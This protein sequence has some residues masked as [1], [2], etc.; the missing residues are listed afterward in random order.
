MN[1]GELHSRIARALGKGTSLDS[2]IPSFVEEGVQWLEA[3]YNF[4]YMKRWVEWTI[5]PNVQQPHVISLYQTKIKK[6]EAVRLVV[7]DP[8]HLDAN[9]AR[10]KD[11]RRIDPKDRQTRFKGPPS[12]YWLDGMQ[13]IVLDSIPTEAGI[14]EGHYIAFTSWQPNEPEFR[15]YLIDRYLTPLIART[16]MIAAIDRRDPRMYDMYKAAYLDAQTV[17]NVSEEDLQYGSGDQQMSW[18]PE[19]IFN[20]E[21]DQLVLQSNS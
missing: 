12:G 6:I 20:T 7:E 15:H 16:C 17:I 1:L 13:S 9:E 11:L 8:A 21:L 3:N 19:T 18:S 2:S 14:I 10:F 5:D 4:Q